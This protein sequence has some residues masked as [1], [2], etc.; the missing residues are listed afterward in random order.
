MEKPAG[1]FLQAGAFNKVLVAVKPLHHLLLY[2]LQLDSF[3]A[4][5]PKVED[6]FF[7]A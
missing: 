4:A 1:Y 3:F 2:F 7:L 5:I 6:N